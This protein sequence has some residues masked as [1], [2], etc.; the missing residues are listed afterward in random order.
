MPRVPFRP[1]L[2]LALATVLLSASVGSFAAAQATGLSFEVEVSERYTREMVHGDVYLILAAEL[3]G[4]PRE[5]LDDHNMKGFVLRVPAQDIEP[6]GKVVIDAGTAGYPDSLA[7]LPPGEYAI[8]AVLDRSLVDPDFTRAEGNGRSRTKRRHLDPSATER[9][10]I[11]IDTEILRG[12]LMDVP[13]V[14]YRKVE[15][16]LIGRALGHRFFI[17]VAVVVPAGYDAESAKQYPVQY[18]FPGHGERSRGALKY[19]QT[20][21][22]F[23]APIGDEGR[24][25][26][27]MVL[28]DSHGR[29][30][31]HFWTD[32]PTNGPCEK[33]F[34]DEVLP[35]IEKDFNVASDA[36]GR[37]LAGH[38]AGGYSALHLLAR[39]PGHFA[40]AFALAPEPV[41]FRSFYGMDLYAANPNAY[42]VNGRERPLARLDGRVAITFREQ[43]RFEEVVGTGNQFQSFEAAFS[44]SGSDGRTRPLFDRETGAVDADV[45]QAWS[46]ADLRLRLR[47]EWLRVGG[48]L[49]GKIH[50]YVGEDD[51]Y[52]LAAPLL[53]LKT[54]LEKRNA[55]PTIKVLAGHDHAALDEEAIHQRV[56]RDIER[57]WLSR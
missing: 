34:F 12:R 32:S 15:S 22:I 18:W 38:G 17:N 26:F 1:C 43:A 55:N 24:T 5:K 31:H 57:H 23:N 28:I 36:S 30:G 46:D 37:Y 3:A 35:Q 25:G 39:R 45:V 47:R 19:F 10:S 11:A 40:G 9:I 29:N 54:M 2:T 8:Q 14:F 44:P 33:A 4:E 21:G 51:N 50:A 20:R 49:G 42:T 48:K 7:A 13:R 16:R 53:A 56:Q 41:D 52:Y 27:V 6:G